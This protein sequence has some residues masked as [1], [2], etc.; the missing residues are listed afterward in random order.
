MEELNA[1]FCFKKINK[2]NSL[3]LT[4]PKDG[5]LRSIFVYSESGKEIVDWYMAIR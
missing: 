1:T 3:Q 2:Q 5:K 4:Y